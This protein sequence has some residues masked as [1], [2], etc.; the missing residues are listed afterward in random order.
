MLA[1]A[2]RYHVQCRFPIT[3]TRF[4]T[5]SMALLDS[6]V[7]YGHEQVVFCSDPVSGLRAIIA[8]HNTTLGPA[9]GGTRMW[10]YKSDSAAR[11]DVL[12]LSRGMT[13]KAAIAGLN[14]GGGKAVIIGDP[15][16]NKSE[17]LFRSFGRFVEGLGGRY[18]TAEDVGTSVAD[19]AWVRMETKHVTGVNSAGGSGDPSP[20]TAYGVYH[21]IKAAA[22][23]AFGNDSLNR[24]KI[25]VQGAGNVASHLVAHLVHE[26]AKVTVSDIYDDKV[27]QL[28]A[29]HNVATVEPDAIYDVDC[30]IF[31]PCALGA[32]INDDT[33]PRLHARV[34][35][36]GANNQLD[37]PARHAPILRERGILYIP[38][39]VINAGG[40]MNVALELEGYSRERAL[41]RAES[42]YGIVENILKLSESQNILTVEAS[43]RLAEERIGAI[44]HIK[45]R[46][47]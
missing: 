21:G 23:K 39:Y 41:Q 38:D 44:G 19:M 31:A 22:K 8:I 26:G 10:H 3:E 17:A 46:H 43:D 36:G 29:D 34:I 25:A 47:V 12:R 1:N 40:L 6:M 18:I 45:Q 9:L 32:C 11:E 37:D 35:A 5:T 2:N 16:R 20:F 4:P 15:R 30:D 27:Q 42:I 28:V 33:I 7:D 24:R 13:Y 14:L